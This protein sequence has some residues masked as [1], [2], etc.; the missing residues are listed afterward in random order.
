[1][2]Y[3]EIYKKLREEYTDAEIAEGYLIPPDLT[4]EEELEIQ[5]EIREVRFKLLKERT[6]EQRLLSDILRLRFQMENY[7]NEGIYAAGKN[8]GGFLSDYIH[9]LKK[10]KKAFAEDIGLHYTRLSRILNNREEP[11][12][13]LTYRLEKHSGELI[14]AL[15]W[16]KISI[17]KQEHLLNKDLK[18]RKI[19]AAKVKNALKFNTGR[20]AS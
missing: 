2:T 18:T 7:Y 17:K 20:T 10:T 1:M 3:E 9:I 8:F 19:E 15:L 13:E 6:E 14:P 4:E 11:N 5:A 16:W 12:V